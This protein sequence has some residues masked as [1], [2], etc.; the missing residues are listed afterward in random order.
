MSTPTNT[1]E[2]G[3]DVLDKLLVDRDDVLLGR[4]D[5]IILVIPTDNSRPRIGYIESGLPTL[6]RRLHPLVAMV[7][8]KIVRKIGL[9]WRRP[10]RLSWSQV[11]SVAKEVRLNV[12]AEESP[13]LRTER[14]LRKEVICRI[15]GNGAKEA[16]EK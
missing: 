11:L 4:V 5:S 1:I 13:Y 3:R 8:R 7:L 14:W 6:A 10:T 16:A 2:L 9:P 15:P 12:C